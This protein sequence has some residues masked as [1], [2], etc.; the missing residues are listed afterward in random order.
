[1]YTNRLINEKSPYLLQHAH[2]PVDWY[3]WGEE[4]ITAAQVQNKPIFLSIGYAT[5]HWCHVM[6]EES[7]ENEEVADLLND[8]FIN[9]K[10]DRE[11]QPEVDSIY[12]EFAQSMM[13]GAAGWP[14]NVILTPDLEPFFAATYLPPYT[15]HGLMGLIEVIQKIKELWQSEERE[16][17]V[18]Q[19]SKIVEIFADSVSPIGEEVLDKEV[20]D[21]TADQ[22]FKMADSVY[23]GIK[24]IPKFPVGYQS[25]FML[26]YASSSKDSRALFLVD[27]TLTMMQRGGIYDHLGGGFSR[28]SVDEQWLVPHF[29]KMLYDNALLSYAYLEAWQFTKN[30]LYKKITTEILDYILRDMRSPEGGFY[31]AEDADSE[32]KEGYFYTWTYEEVQN[33]LGEQ[34]KLF[35]DYYQVMPEGNFGKRNIIHTPMTIEEFAQKKGMDASFLEKSLEGQK[36]LLWKVREGRVHPFKDDKILTSWNGLMITSLAEAG[37]AFNNQ[38]YIE[39]AKQAAVFIKKNLW[40]N[41]ILYRRYREME[42]SFTGGLEE[43]A[44]L[45]RGLLSLFQVD[46]GTEW[47][48]WALEL[49]HILQERYKESEGAFYQ[50]DGQ[51]KNLILRRCHFSDGAEPSGNAIHTENLIKLYHMTGNIDYLEQA[52]DVMKAAKEPIENYLPGYCYHIMNIQYY[53]DRHAPTIVIAL[54]EAEDNKDLIRRLIYE[55]FIPHKSIIWKRTNDKELI[56]LIPSCEKQGLENNQTTVYFCEEG[57]CKRPITSMEECAKFIE[58]WKTM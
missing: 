57:V 22:L 50:T 52:E 3:P 34:A 54:N 16:K 47:L 18:D 11:E 51:D 58:N 15:K 36:K 33:I 31:S 24:G 41:G 49:T 25:N 56:R 7:F 12:M 13:S 17:V 5:C 38:N 39:A 1:M 8:A 21:D 4:A 35:C 30:S 53:Y 37:A 45:I 32:G 6:E 44:F 23:G 14:L 20:V 10:I 55:H 28:Y 48:K 43:Y 19:A 27:K 26:R 29:E 46:Q 9:I 2:N 40:K 42:V